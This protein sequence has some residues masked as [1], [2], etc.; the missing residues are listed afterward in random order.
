MFG[1]GFPFD[2][3]LFFLAVGILMGVNRS[4]LERTR[5]NE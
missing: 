1:D 3:A 2:I 4:K 5:R